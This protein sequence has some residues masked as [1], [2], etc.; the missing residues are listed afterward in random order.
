MKHRYVGPVTTFSDYH[1]RLQTS[2][3][4]GSKSLERKDLELMMIELKEQRILER[5]QETDK[6]R[7]N[8]VDGIRVRSMLR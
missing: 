1:Q 3:K 7:R 6:H 4:E 8:I 2:M 5:L